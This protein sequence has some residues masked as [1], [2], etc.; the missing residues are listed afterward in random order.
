MCLCTVD[1]QTRRRI[2]SGELKDYY[3]S[4]GNS[5]TSGVD[6]EVHIRKK[7]GTSG[8][9]DSRKKATSKHV[10]FSTSPKRK[11]KPLS[12]SP[13]KNVSQGAKQQ[14]TSPRKKSNIPLSPLKSGMEGG[15]ANIERSKSYSDGTVRFNLCACI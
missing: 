7:V 4:D 11:P 5:T 8:V 6:E 1:R 9:D 2:P 3:P 14:R 10:C 15:G 12:S 13:S